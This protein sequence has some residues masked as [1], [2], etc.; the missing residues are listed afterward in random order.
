MHRCWKE[1]IRQSL[2]SHYAIV[3]W[4]NVLRQT[5]SLLVNKASDK[6]IIM[7]GKHKG[8]LIIVNPE[9]TRSKKEYSHESGEIVWSH[10]RGSLSKFEVFVI[11]KK[12]LKSS[13][14]FWIIT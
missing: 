14:I 7:W 12:S 9:M 3:P 4:Q 11:H 1:E 8:V 10:H 6:V 13:W 5:Q 2:Y